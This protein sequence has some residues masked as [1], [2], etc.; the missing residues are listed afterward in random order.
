M[1]GNDAV[2]VRR[3]HLGLDV[4]SSFD[5]ERCNVVGTAGSAPELCQGPDGVVMRRHVL[6]LGPG[7][8]PR[9]CFPGEP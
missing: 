9:N 2:L 1:L 5:P 6:G 3:W 7:V 8:Q 4:P